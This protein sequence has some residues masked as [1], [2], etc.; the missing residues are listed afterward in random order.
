M[1]IL[2]TNFFAT[3]FREIF[4][5]F[6]T[7]IFWLFEKVLVNVFKVAYADIFTEK[8]INDVLNRLYIIIGLF[9][10]FKL[11][12]SIITYI[13]SPD[14]MVDKQKGFSQIITRVVIS[15]SL[16]ILVPSIFRYAKLAQGYI[17]PVIPKIIIGKDFSGNRDYDIGPN[18]GTDGNYG[19]IS[20]ETLDKIAKSMSFYSYLVIFN[21][22]D[23][24]ADDQNTI[25]GSPGADESTI[26]VYTINDVPGVVSQTCDVSKTGQTEYKYR[27]IPFI[28]TVLGGFLVYVMLGITIDV[29]IRTIKLGLLQILAPIPIISYIDPKSKDGAFSNW[30]KTCIST[31]IDLFIRIGLIYLMMYIFDSLFHGDI[32]TSNEPLVAGSIIVGLFFFVK[33]A[34]KFIKDIL[35]I[36]GEMG[37]FKDVMTGRGLAGLATGWM[38]GAVDAKKKG[39]SAILGGLSGGFAAGKQF[40][41]N[42]MQGKSGGIWKAAG[43]AG[44]ESQKINEGWRGRL[45]RAAGGR[46]ADKLGYTQSRIDNLEAA[47]TKAKNDAE[48]KRM[49]WENAVK[50]GESAEVI[51]AR[52]ESYEG[53]LK[54]ANKIESRLGQVKDERKRLVGPISAREKPR[55]SINEK[56]RDG[57]SAARKSYSEDSKYLDDEVKQN[58]RRVRELEQTI[59]YGDPEVVSLATAE[60]DRLN[61]EIRIADELRRE[62]DTNYE[63]KVETLKDTRNRKL[64]EAKKNPDSDIL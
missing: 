58:R 13:I 54:Y 52:R 11:A 15:L 23:D 14:V 39:G 45:N 55:E 26:K 63:R 20:Q 53:A 17:L 16:L 25:Y 18:A 36:K 19:S 50:N 29:A 24:C 8:I 32:L 41:S 49:A 51:A 30:V 44:E 60:R 46:Y 2:A 9:I 4:A 28:G 3:K 1:F 27:Y 61:E 7:G 5:W 34:P 38:K 35:G 33:S 37:M 43:K 6:D 56:Y 47:S 57:Y 59:R 40:F 22:N 31:Y 42:A 21:Y 10:L 12:F 64:E 62:L 48:E